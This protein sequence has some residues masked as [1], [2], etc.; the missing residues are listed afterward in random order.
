METLALIIDFISDA[1]G[2]IVKAALVILAIVVIVGLFKTCAA[3]ATLSEHSSCHQFEQADTATQDKVLQDMMAAHHTHDGIALTRLSVTLYCNVHDDNS[4]IDGVYNSSNVSQQ[5]ALASTAT[6]TVTTERF[7]VGETATFRGWKVTLKS[8]RT[9]RNYKADT[10]LPFPADTHPQE[11]T[12]LICRVSIFNE[13]AQDTTLSAA[14]NFL[15]FNVPFASGDT[16]YPS[17]MPTSKADVIDGQIPIGSG[18]E[19]DLVYIVGDNGVEVLNYKLGFGFPN[20]LSQE[21]LSVWF[22]FSVPPW[23]S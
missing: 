19:G 4:P 9:D 23:W 17:A 18:V 1:W 22:Y 12:Y 3:N 11:V 10:P 20:A 16:W 15:L 7:A 2:L 8:V 21:P 13:S 6:P 14:N 5:S